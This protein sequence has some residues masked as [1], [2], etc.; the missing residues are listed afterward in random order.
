MSAKGSRSTSG[1][2]LLDP[3]LP[4]MTH[5]A[6]LNRNPDVFD[7]SLRWVPWQYEPHLK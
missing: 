3:T 4:V 7:A 2:P 5:L 1:K 6:V